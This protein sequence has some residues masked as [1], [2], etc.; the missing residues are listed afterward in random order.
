[1]SVAM[2]GQ[3]WNYVVIFSVCIATKINAGLVVLRRVV[4]AVRHKRIY[5]S[6]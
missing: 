3:P 6:T 1:M 4:G 2:D 5:A